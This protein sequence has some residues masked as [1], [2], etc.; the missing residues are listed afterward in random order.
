METIQ[1]VRSTWHSTS[2]A[3]ALHPDRFIPARD[4]EH[5]A[6]KAFFT[7]LCAALPDAYVSISRPGNRISFGRK[8]IDLTIDREEV[9]VAIEVKFKVKSDCA[10]RDNRTA[11]FDDIAK[12]QEYTRDRAYTHGVFLWLTDCPEYYHDDVSAKSDCSTHDGRLYE[13]ST[14]LREARA[15]D[16]RPREW[17]FPWQFSFTWNQCVANPTWRWVMI[18]TSEGA[19]GISSH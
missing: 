4:K 11:S 5:R 14:L 15:R 6:K 1:K 7:E 9:R 13:A 19:D 2:E 8:E 3:V 18:Q 17:S 10:Y 12:L 16:G